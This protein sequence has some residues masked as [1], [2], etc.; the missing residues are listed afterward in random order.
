M[1]GTRALTGCA[2]WP[3]FARTRAHRSLW[4]QVAGQGMEG[5]GNFGI[6]VV[7]TTLERLRVYYFPIVVDPEEP[8]SMS[9]ERYRSVLDC[10]SRKGWR[11]CTRHAITWLDQPLS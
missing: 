10:V 5:C 4:L 9:E 11:A 1:T 3:C 8:T 2:R 6:P 7:D